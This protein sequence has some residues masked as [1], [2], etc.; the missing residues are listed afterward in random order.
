MAFWLD[1]SLLSIGAAGEISTVLR[2][3]FC[4]VVPILLIVGILFSVVKH[5]YVSTPIITNQMIDLVRQEPAARAARAE[6]T[7][8]FFLERR[9]AAH[10]QVFA[11]VLGERARGGRRA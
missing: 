2:R 11:E 6:V 1:D 7:R 4:V 8:R 3:A 10:V 9:M 5:Y